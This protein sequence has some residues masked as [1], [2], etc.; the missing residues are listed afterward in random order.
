MSC[1]SCRL[2]NQ[3]GCNHVWRE[4]YRPLPSPKSS[5]FRG[6]DES[7]LPQ[8]AYVAGKSE[9]FPFSGSSDLSTNV[10][11]VDV[12]LRIGLVA[13]NPFA[14]ARIRQEMNM[15]NNDDFDFILMRL[16]M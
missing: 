16:Y 4:S 3:E 1:L 11:S 13:M 14:T 9:E 15:C 12:Q 5:G 8:L 10:F 2:S 6:K 7:H